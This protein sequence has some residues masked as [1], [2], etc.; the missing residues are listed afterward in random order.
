MNRLFPVILLAMS[1]SAHADMVLREDTASQV[2]QLG[3]FVDETGAIVDDLTIANTDVRLSK[4]GANIVGKN[5]GGCT[6][7][8]VGMYSCTFDATDSNTAGRLQ[9]IVVKTGALPVYHEFQVATQSVFDACCASGATAAAADGSSFTAIPW[10]ASWD[11]EVQSEAADA[12][13]A[14]DPPTNAE[15]TARTLASASY[16]T[17]ASQSTMDGKLDTIDSLNGAI[18]AKTDQL[19]F[20]VTNTLN[21]NM[22][23]VNGVQ[24]T[25]D[26]SG[27]P[28]NV[29]P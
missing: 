24:L 28:F 23:Y 18:K 4:N 5:S 14:Y 16:A 15:M 13:N 25:G 22:E 2:V 8:E 9:V 1:L 12:L 11:A 10:N 7:D 27:T 17:A 3:P 20:G 21:A 6:Y 29:S 26:G 19:T